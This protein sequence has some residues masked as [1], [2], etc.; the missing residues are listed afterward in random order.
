MEKKTIYNTKPPIYSGK[1]DYVFISYSHLDK[2]I[3]YKDLWDLSEYGINIWYDDGISAGEM[4]NSVVES[5]IKDDKCKFVIFFVSSQTI[6]SSAI[7]REMDIVKTNKKSF[8][9]VNIS[10]ESMPA[11]IGKALSQKKIQL[12]DLSLYSDFFNEDIIFISHNETGYLDKLAKEC[13]KRGIKADVELKTY[14]PAVKKVLIICKNSSFSNSIVNGINTVLSKKENIV[15]DIIFI[16]R[17]KSKVEAMYEFEKA[18]RENA[19]SY[20]AFILRVPEKYN[21]NIIDLINQ[22]QN[23]GKKVLLLDINI[24]SEK[25]KKLS[26]CPGYVGSDFAA[27]GALLGERIGDLTKKFGVKLTSVELFEGP[28]ANSSAKTRCNSLYN[29]LM[30]TV[31]TAMIDR[32]DL[33]STDPAIANEYIDEQAL[34]WR[35]EDR[36]NGRCVILYLGMDNIAVEVMRRIARNNADDVLVESLKQSKKLI[37]VG[38]DGIRDVNGEIILK[39]YGIDYI[40]IDVVPYKQGIDAGNA[41][42]SMLFNFA[43]IEDILTPPEIVEHVRLDTE[44]FESAKDISFILDNKKVFIFDLDGTIADTETLHWEAYASVLKQYGIKLSPEH[45]KKYIGHAETV[46]YR[47]IKEDFHIEF[48]DSEFMEKRI[49]RYLSLV[50]ETNLRPFEFIYEIFESH[51]ATNVLVTSQIPSIVNDLLQLW[52]LTK[53]FVPDHIYCCHDGKYKKN[54]IYKNISRYSGINVKP[55]EVVLFEDAMHYIKIAQQL[56]ITTIGIEH[57]YNRGSLI[58]CDAIL[59]E[60]LTR[61]VFIG[62]CGLDIIYYSKNEFPSE[63][64]KLKIEDY[65]IEIGGPAA[66]AAITYA[67]LGGEAYLICLIGDSAE[68]QMIKTKLKLSNI[69]CIDVALDEN[70]APSISAVFVNTNKSTRT[71]LSGQTNITAS[72]NFDFEDEIKK[73]KFV[74]YDGNASALERRMLKHVDCYDKDLVLDAGSYKP[75]FRECFYHAKTVIAS[76]SFFDQETG[77]IFDC[78]KKYGF[79]NAAQSMGEKPIIVATGG[80]KTEIPILKAKAI[81]TLG[82]GDILHGAYC[83]YRYALDLSFKEALEKASLIATYAV[84]KKGVVE[85]IEHAK[86]VLASL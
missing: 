85:G 9:T 48:D 32:Y 27:G 3:V 31:P 58:N 4:W 65:R 42:Y 81:D 72:A 30:N 41:I 62:L 45:I 10:N 74:L 79:E 76:E 43:K 26:V 55:S 64:M 36:F 17:A 37:I 21:E 49:S 52:G 20:D 24:P 29:Q 25:L 61:G 35:N 57:R 5:K 40:T 22:I 54:E 39:N 73:A 56:G 12:S 19:Q 84:E 68:G 50:K 83:Y 14:K 77:D 69:S 1:D 63:N 47:M 34:I 8:C 66:N 7:R 28:Y 11:L 80:R 46:I 2:E 38:Y 75:G 51:H 33:Q 71:I 67:Q 18:L 82:A 23:D 78:Q 60:K 6:I 53:Y 86:D 59:T 13:F 16:D 15:A 70:D 44:K